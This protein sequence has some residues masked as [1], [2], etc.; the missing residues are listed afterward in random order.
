MANAIP[1]RASINS[2]AVKGYLVLFDGAMLQNRLPVAQ[3][4]GN[5]PLVPHL[6]LARPHDAIEGSHSLV[7]LRLSFQ[8]DFTMYEQT[9]S[10]VP[11]I[12]FNSLNAPLTQALCPRMT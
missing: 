2:H 8:D 6:S 9:G 11:L 7:L 12:F 3:P 5:V 10:I 1:A 4:M